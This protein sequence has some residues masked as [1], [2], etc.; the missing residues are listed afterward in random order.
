MRSVVGF[1]VFSILALGAAT[2][3]VADG[4]PV[5]VSAAPAVHDGWSGLY[6][7]A[8][9]GGSYVD[10]SG[11]VDTDKDVEVKK[12]KC[13]W[14]WC[15][16]DKIYDYSKDY[17]TNIDDKSW[18]GFGTIQVGYDR[19]FHDRFLAGAFADVDLYVDRNDEISGKHI[20]D[21]SLELKHA[22]NVGGRLGALVTPELLL[23]GVGGYSRAS[24]NGSID[25]HNGPTLGLG[26]GLH[27]W[28]MGGGGEYKLR[29][30]IALKLEYRYADYGSFSDAGS[31]WDIDFWKKHGDHYKSI[32]EVNSLVDEDLT[33][34]S[35]RALLVFRLD[36]PDLPVALK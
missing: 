1:S 24:V 6:I 17:S 27:G 26:D 28:F 22:W 14:W 5:S 33:I 11:S 31:T 35:V 15:H 16:W 25:V 32:T 2:A 19:L 21:G 34:Q 13:W 36:E 12:L 8:G 3:A 18:K 9:G 23:Y 10:R 20:D 7:G 29:R 4:T 30:G